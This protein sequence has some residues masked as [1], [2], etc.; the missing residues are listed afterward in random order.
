MTNTILAALFGVLTG[1]AASLAAQDLSRLPVVAAA[2]ADMAAMNTEVAKKRV[3]IALESVHVRTVSSSGILTD[4]TIRVTERAT[5][6]PVANRKVLLKWKPYGA[7]GRYHFLLGGTT[8]ADGRVILTGLHAHALH[9]RLYS[10][11]AV[12]PK[13]QMGYRRS[14]QVSVHV[15]R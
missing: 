14:H 6:T 9:G 11:R 8:G 5:G 2:G 3:A 7:T 13:G 4:Y 15:I 1:T 12:F 10:F